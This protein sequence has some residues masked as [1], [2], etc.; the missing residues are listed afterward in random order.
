M[1]ECTTRKNRFSKLSETVERT[2]A[3]LSAHRQTTRFLSFSSRLFTPA[4][5]IPFQYVTADPAGEGEPS[6][7]YAGGGRMYRSGRI[8]PFHLPRDI[9]RAR[10]ST[11]KNDRKLYRVYCED[12]L[13]RSRFA[14]ASSKSPTLSLSLSLF[15]TSFFFFFSRTGT[16]SVARRTWKRFQAGFPSRRSLRT[17]VVAGIR[18]PPPRPPFSSRFH[19]RTRS[20]V[21][22]LIVRR[23]DESTGERV[24]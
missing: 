16:S 2:A 20:I 23:T 12:E 11:R 21:M 14:P 15:F 1:I 24:L 8:C 7:E 17:L 22:A 3:A 13:G 9:F 6:F 4:S 10:P 19:S 18:L 5:S